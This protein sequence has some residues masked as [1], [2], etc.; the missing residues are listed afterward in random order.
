MY[1]VY[2]R[3]SQTGRTLWMLIV[4]YLV[5]VFM[6]LEATVIMNETVQFLHLFILQFSLQ[7]QSS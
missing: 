1:F 4:K 2:G 5:A 6:V 7:T 3:Y